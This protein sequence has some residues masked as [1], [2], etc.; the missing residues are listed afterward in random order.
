[1]FYSRHRFGSLPTEIQVTVLCAMTAA[2]LIDFRCCSVASNALYMANESAIVRGVLK[3]VYYH[4]ASTLYGGSASATGPLRFEC[5]KYIARRCSIVEMLAISVAEHHVGQGLA[6]TIRMGE[7]LR[8]YLLALGHFFEEFR[9]GLPKFP[10]GSPPA[11]AKVEGEI[12]EAN[13]NEQT[14]QRMCLTYKILNQILDQK[15]MVER[16]TIRDQLP[17]ALPWLRYHPSA[18]VDMFIFGGLEMVKDM[19]THPRLIDRRVYAASHFSKTTP[20]PIPMVGD[21]SVAVALPPSVLGRRLSLRTTRQI[22]VLFPVS[23]PLQLR[24]LEYSGFSRVEAAEELDM[25]RDFLEYLKS[26]DGEEPKLVL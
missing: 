17:V 10:S 4:T 3:N 26:Y 21:D 12:L 1:M 2:E 20:A 18:P 6:T 7:N 5:L 16:P 24:S 14:V 13:Y 25:D 22:N 19:M 23:G 15:F 9:I 11:P 8:P